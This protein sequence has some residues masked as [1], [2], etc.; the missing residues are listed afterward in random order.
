MNIGERLKEE[1]ERLGYS[2]YDFAAI[3]GS[4][5]GSQI[6]W[7]KGRAFPN[8][9]YLEAIAATGADILYIV[10]GERIFDE[11]NIEPRSRDCLIEAA[12]VIQ[13]WQVESGKLLPVDKFVQAIDLL[14]ELA[15]GEHEQIKKHSAKVLWLA[16]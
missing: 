9:E 8:A 10:T 14:I 11:Q 5:K 15:D 16:A 1:R 2:Q 13:E 12:K 3:T 7:E 4:S 6:S